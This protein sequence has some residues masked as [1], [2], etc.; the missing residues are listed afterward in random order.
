MKKVTYNATVTYLP[1][2]EEFIKSSAKLSA[3]AD[4]KEK[5]KS[6]VMARANSLGKQVTITEESVVKV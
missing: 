6:S 2:G 1:R 5:A 3:T 4:T